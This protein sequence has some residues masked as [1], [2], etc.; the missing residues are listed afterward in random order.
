MSP[1]PAFSAPDADYAFAMD[2]ATA[3]NS[4]INKFDGTN[5]HTWKFKV[6]MVLEERDLWEV[7]SGEIKLEQLV[8]V[9]D[10]QRSRVSHERL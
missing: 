8:T 7:A 5:F 10:H 4:R 2:A 9:L 3:T 6:Q 1:S